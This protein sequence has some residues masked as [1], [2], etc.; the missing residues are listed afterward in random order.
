MGA[1]RRRSSGSQRDP[2]LH[3]DTKQTCRLGC[4]PVEGLT[5]VLHAHRHVAH[6]VAVS[7]DRSTLAAAACNPGGSSAQPS[8]AIGGSCWPDG[9]DRISDGLVARAAGWRRGM[10]RILLPVKLCNVNWQCISISRMTAS[11][12][13][14]VFEAAWLHTEP[15]SPPSLRVLPSSVRCQEASTTGHAPD[16]FVREA[17]VHCRLRLHET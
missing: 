17:D 1:A 7:R 4:G 12:A 3:L 11:H 15:D 2:P 14:P 9:V 10:A 8:S 13:W 6:D 5:E 16:A